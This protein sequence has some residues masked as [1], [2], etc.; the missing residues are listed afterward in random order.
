LL[1]TLLININTFPIL[2]IL[3]LN[4]SD[5]YNDIVDECTVVMA[6]LRRHSRYLKLK[7]KSVR[8]DL[9]LQRQ[10]A[11]TDHLELQNLLYEAIHLNK[12]VAAV[13]DY[14]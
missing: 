3:A 10:S 13:K 4:E 11:D 7:L 2:Q 5:D 14:K 12:Q 9:I 6:D 1:L 8:D